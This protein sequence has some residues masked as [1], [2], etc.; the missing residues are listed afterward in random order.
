MFFEL[1]CLC[2]NIYSCGNPVLSVQHADWHC[3]GADCNRCHISTSPSVEFLLQVP[4]QAP[5]LS[6]GIPEPVER[7]LWSQCEGGQATQRGCC[8]LWQDVWVTGPGEVPSG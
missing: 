2:D 7:V 8:A 1:D 3:H 4:F 6:A 5:L